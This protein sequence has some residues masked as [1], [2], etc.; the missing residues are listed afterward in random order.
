MRFLIFKRES[1]VEA[2]YV[3]RQIGLSIADAIPDRGNDI[4]GAQLLDLMA[5]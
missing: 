5:V 3:E 1:R 4:R 2:V